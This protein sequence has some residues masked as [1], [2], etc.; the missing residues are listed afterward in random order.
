MQHETGAVLSDVTYQKLLRWLVAGGLEPNTRLP[1][2]HVL[3]AQFAVSRPVLRQA[4]ARLRAEGRLYSRKGSGT[5]VQVRSDAAQPAAYAALGSIPDVR[6]FLEFRCGVEGEMAAAAAACRTADDLA[7]IEQCRHAVEVETAAGR[8]GIEQDVALHAAVARAS[9]NRFYVETLTSLAE[10]IRFSIR[11][12][13]ELTTQSATE[14]TGE[15]HREHARLCNAIAARVPDDARHAM[16][17]HLRGGL[18]RLFG[19]PDN[20]LC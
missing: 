20:A 14:R 3:A 10:Q 13:R 18:A 9:G 6:S 15:L 19:N 2:E 5:F 1:G 4:L 8:P 7:A 12:T 11:L 16:H 17:D